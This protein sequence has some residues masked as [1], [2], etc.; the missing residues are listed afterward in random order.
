MH[1]CLP[2]CVN[3]KGDLIS[4]SA[5]KL[6]VI[7]MSAVTAILG[8]RTSTPNEQCLVGIR[9]PMLKSSIISLQYQ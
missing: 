9:Q 8:V 4:I 7:Y 1:A 3:M 6:N 2:Y 5:S